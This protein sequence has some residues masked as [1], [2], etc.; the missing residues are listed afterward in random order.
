MGRCGPIH[1]RRVVRAPDPKQGERIII[2]TTQARR[3]QGRSARLDEDQ[4]ASEIM[5]PAAVLVL[6]AIPLLG[7]GKTDYVELEKIVRG[8]MA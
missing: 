8:K 3:D 2:A 7:S 5:A 4:G 6:D 1:R